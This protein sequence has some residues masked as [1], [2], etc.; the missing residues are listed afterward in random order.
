MTF[1]EAVQVCLTKYIGFVGRAPRSEYW[2]FFVFNLLVSLGATTLDAA[3]GGDLIATVAA[4][5]LFLPSLAV[6]VR[7]LHDTGRS[8]WWMLIALVPVVG[9]IVLVVF[10]CLPGDRASNR[11]GA[12]F[13][14]F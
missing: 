6:G 9:W 2:W 1:I 13:V 5:A 12:P 10:F 3:V 14:A 11:Y 4:L 8:G 7:R